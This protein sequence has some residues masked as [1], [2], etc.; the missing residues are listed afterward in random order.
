MKSLFTV[1]PLDERSNLNWLMGQPVP[2]SHPF[3]QVFFLTKGTGSHWVDGIETRLEAPWVMLIAKGKKHLFLPDVPAEGWMFDFGEDF[4][5][6][7]ASWIFS[8]FLAAPN[9]PLHDDALVRQ[10]SALARLLWDLGQVAREETR[11][12]IR[13][14]LAAFLH[15]FQ[16]RIREQAARAQAQSSADFKLFQAFLHQLDKSFQEEKE[17]EFYARKLRCTPRR[18]GTACKA[19]LGKTPQTLIIERVMLEAKRLLL[20]TDMSVQQIASLLGCEEHSN[21]TKAFRKATGETPSAFRRTRQLE[22]AT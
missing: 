15:L 9:L 22:S 3:H 20:H 6:D 17:V 4:L 11:P 2:H 5:D 21:F 8:D 13:H 18:L 19:V 16:A 12:A 14:L 1:W 7:D 10:A